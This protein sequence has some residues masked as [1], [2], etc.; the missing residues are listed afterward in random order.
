MLP[1][2]FEN[3]AVALLRLL[4]RQADVEDIRLRVDGGL[5]N[6]HVLALHTAGD[7]ALGIIDV[8]EDARGAGAGVHARGTQTGGE[9]VNAEVALVHLL[10]H[11]VEKAYGGVRAVLDALSAGYAL[12]R[13]N[14]DDAVLLA[15]ESGFRGAVHRADGKVAVIAHQGQIEHQFLPVDL[16]SG[17]ENGGAVLVGKVPVFMTATH[18]AC[19]AAVA[20]AKVDQHG[21]VRLGLA[22][23]FREDGS[24][25][26]ETQR[27]RAK[28]A[29]RHPCK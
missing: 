7:L 9:T 10:R 19:T 22:A 11:P 25:R 20:A 8:A 16:R 6:E 17:L 27:R 2:R 26:H 1:I 23:D 15:L 28:R 5:E 29:A 3:Q 13:I 24:G 4:R 14:H 21:Q 12:R 18:D